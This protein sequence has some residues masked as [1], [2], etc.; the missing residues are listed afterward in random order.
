MH[1]TEREFGSRNLIDT[2]IEK[3]TSSYINVGV[4]D[5][6][7]EIDHSVG[8]TSNINCPLSLI[9]QFLNIN[10]D[11]DN[12]NENK[13]DSEYDNDKQTVNFDAPDIE[14]HFDNIPITSINQGFAW[15]IY[16]NF[17]D[18]I[19]YSEFLTSLYMARK[20]FGVSDQA[21]KYA[22]CKKCCKLYVIKD[23]LIDEPYHCTYQDFPNHLMANL[24]SPCN[25]IITK[26]D[27]KN[28]VGNGQSD[29]IIIRSYRIYTMEEFG[30]ISK[31]QQITKHFSDMN[32]YNRSI[33]GIVEGIDLSSTYESS[34]GKHIRAAIICCA[35]DI[36]AA[37]KLCGHISA[38]I[39]CYRCKKKANIESNFKANFGG[40]TN[41]DQWFVPRD[42]KEIKNNASL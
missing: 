19:A 40:F 29:P 10:E 21:I 1:M 30:K 34:T 41:I 37:Q 33:Y 2:Q 36:P 24:R 31:I 9:E 11:D 7:M 3:E 28:P 26:Q 39:A 20:L 8:N 5:N 42:V 13:S 12:G 4:S 23:L 14:D 27:L 17:Y 25:A 32:S 16:A 38:C 6:L 18:K 22:T 15:I 35:C